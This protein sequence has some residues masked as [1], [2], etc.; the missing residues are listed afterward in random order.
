M[1]IKSSFIT[2]TKH[3]ID[4]MSSRSIPPIF[5][6]RYPIVSGYQTSINRFD[7][8]GKFLHPEKFLLDVMLAMPLKFLRNQKQILKTYSRLVTLPYPDLNFEEYKYEVVAYATELTYAISARNV[9]YDIRRLERVEVAV[10]AKLQGYSICN[11]TTFFLHAVHLALMR[12]V[13]GH[14]GSPD[15]G[16]YGKIQRVWDAIPENAHKQLMFQFHGED[17][18][19]VTLDN[20]VDLDDGFSVDTT[21]TDPVEYNSDEESTP[22]ERVFGDDDEDD[23]YFQTKL[24][25]SELAEMDP[26]VLVLVSVQGMAN[27]VW[28]IKLQ[29][30]PFTN[31]SPPLEFSEDADPSED[32]VPALAG[33]PTEIVV[34]EPTTKKPK[35]E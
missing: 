14:F 5:Q 23:Q 9:A 13:T 15:S 6:H 17:G 18:G 10:M 30:S 19:I 20:V 35:T 31:Y 1:L 24:T 33:I 26:S 21:D 28:E 12:F 11:D 3:N 25:E 4:D 32:E 27:A 29:H 16:F 2:N 8:Y 34:Y 22:S 7:K